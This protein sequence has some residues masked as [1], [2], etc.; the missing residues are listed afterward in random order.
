MDRHRIDTLHNLGELQELSALLGLPLAVFDTE[1]TGLLQSPKTEILEI[2]VVRVDASG[3][4]YD[5]CFIRNTHPIPEKLTRDVHGID[6]AMTAGG[7][8]PAEAFGI[9][10]GL[11]EGHVVSGFNINDFDLPLLSMCMLRAGLTPLEPSSTPRLDVRKVHIQLNNGRWDGKLC[12]LCQDRGID[13]PGAHSALADAAMSA[14]LL[15]AY[16]REHGAA[17]VAGFAKGMPAGAPGPR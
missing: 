2:G 9:L 10:A 5:A 12:A 17:F 7:L 16:V 13:L 6:D 4:K 15:G 14:G 1:T 11:L 8:P 3:W